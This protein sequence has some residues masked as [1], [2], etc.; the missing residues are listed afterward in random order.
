M[1][2]TLTLPND[3]ATFALGRW[4]GQH[5]AA[6]TVLL[7]KG[8][9]GSGKTTLTKGLGEGLGIA[10][11]IDS[12]TFT[13]INEYVG[14]RLP[15]YHVDLYRLESA[16]TDRL[17]LESYWEGI[18]YPPGIVAIEWAERLRYLPPASLEV[19]LTYQHPEGRKGVLIPGNSA[20]TRLLEELTPDA[21]LAHEV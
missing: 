6:G 12:P 11:E 14:D 13:L 3:R 16:D 21:I 17:F 4:L 10:E 5:L 9:L 8:D 1:S 19:R 18:E 2:K 20:Q 15:L 7:L